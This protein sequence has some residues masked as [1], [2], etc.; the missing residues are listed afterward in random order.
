MIR[1][2]WGRRVGGDRHSISGGERVMSAGQGHRPYGPVS[3]G[4]RPFLRGGERLRGTCRRP[5]LTPQRH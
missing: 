5:A 2:V 4:W 3:A 1:L